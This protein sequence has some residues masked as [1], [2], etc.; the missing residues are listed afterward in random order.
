MSK[1]SKLK[2][3]ITLS[4]KRKQT[5]LDPTPP[6][7]PGPGGFN[8]RQILE[9]VLRWSLVVVIFVVLMGA[10]TVQETKEGELRQLEG[11]LASMQAERDLLK[12]NVDLFNDPAW[13]EAYWKY[14]TMRHKPGEY[15]IEFIEPG[16]L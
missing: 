16:S 2:P 15:Y 14:Q 4:R 9:A 3:K 7:D 8:L 5:G 13:R 11:E 12:E 6:V 10:L 1:K